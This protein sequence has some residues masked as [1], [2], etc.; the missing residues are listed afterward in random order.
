M[1]DGRH[2]EILRAGLSRACSLR[3]DLER[4]LADIAESTSQVLDDEHDAE[5]STVGYERARVTALLAATRREIDD[6]TDALARATGDAPAEACAYGRCQGCGAPIGAERL[7]AIPTAV[8]CMTCA[9][10]G[11]HAGFRLVR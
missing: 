10:S 9:T 3:A 2:I 11:T 8:T 1:A 6:L 7:A 4:E 5:G